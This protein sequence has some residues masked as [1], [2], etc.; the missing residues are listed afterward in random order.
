VTF[1]V[2]PPLSQ[3]NKVFNLCLFAEFFGVFFTMGENVTLAA[4]G[5]KKSRIKKVF[6]FPGIKKMMNLDIF[7]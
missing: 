5:D 2:Y 1:I 3:R 4:K 6:F 7:F